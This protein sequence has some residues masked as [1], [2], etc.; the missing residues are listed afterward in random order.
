MWVAIHIASSKPAADKIVQ[1]LSDEG[2]LVKT[3]PVYKNVSSRG[4][5]YEILVLKS[6]A[7][8]A[9]NILLLNGYWK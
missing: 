3:N 1:I 6:E 4:N 2:F 9:R 8:D 5:H 7:Y